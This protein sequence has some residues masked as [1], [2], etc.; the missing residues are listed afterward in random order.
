MK[1]N[2]VIKE[3]KKVKNNK[4]RNIIVLIS[5]L[6]T[7]FIS[8][9]L[10]RGTYLETLEIGEKYINAFW[11]NTKYVFVT[12]IVNAVFLYLSIYF[13]NIK[14][15]NNLAVFF[16]E[17]KKEMIK[18][19]NK[20][21]AFVLSIIVSTITTK[22]LANKAILFFN[23]TLFG[24]F[25]PVTGH[26]IGYFMFQKPLIEFIIMYLLI[27]VVSLVI[28][29]VFYYIITINICFDGINMK[30][31]K[32][33]KIINVLTHY[34]KIFAI[35]ISCLVF[36]NTQSISTNNY[37]D[38]KE[39]QGKFFLIGAGAS[40]IAIKIWG[41]R[42]LCVLIILSVFIAVNQFKKRK[43]KN[44]LVS[45]LIVPTYLILFMISIFGYNTI[46][47]NSNELD[48][49][50]SYIQNNINY[51][52]KAYGISIDEVLIQNGNTITED[53][54][55]KNQTV[56]NNISI[57]NKDMLLKDLQASQ[58][59]KGYYSYTNTQMAKYNIN[60]IDKTIYISPRE[61]SNN[62]VT[63]N[64]KTYEFTHGYGAIIT[65]ASEVDSNGNLVHLQ[66]GFSDSEKLLNIKEPRLYF[67]LETTDTIVTNCNKQNEFDYPI[68]D[69][70][71][72][73]TKENTYN[74]KAGLKLSFIDRFILALKEG[75]IKLA[76]SENVGKNSKILTN[77]NIIDRAKKIMPYLIYDE[78]PYVVINSEGRI[79]WVLDAYTISNQ[80]PYS[81]KTTI[82]SN[83]I[84]KKEFNY[85]RNSVKVLIDS[86]DG[87]ID[88]YITDKTD[89]I[90]MAYKK[91]YK[92]L[93][94][95]EEIP[96]DIKEHLIYPEFLYNIQAKILT[97]YHNVTPDVL[98]RSYDTWD[99]CSHNTG[100]VLT[101]AGTTFNPY[102]TMCKLQ[103]KTESTFGLC[104]PF[105]QYGKQ[106]I[107][108]YLIG[109]YDRS[110]KPNLTLYK[111]PSD[112]NVLGPMQLDTQIEQ[113]EK[114]TK[115]L[116]SL[117]VNG[118]KITKN[119]IVVPVNNTLLYVETI[120]QQYLNE[121]ESALPTLKKVI[122]AS[123]NKL[124]IG[125]NFKESL[126]NLVSQYAVNIEPGVTDNIDDLIDFLI[127]AN[128]NLEQSTNS[129]DWEMM[130]KDVKKLQEIINKLEEVRD[131]EKKK[132]EETL[133]SV[134]TEDE[135][136]E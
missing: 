79:I 24:D 13:T 28:Y 57:T 5:Y 106:N 135:V 131:E 25:D 105:T 99:I 129:K 63:Y 114:I 115:Q 17:E 117:N 98:Y 11:T 62:N 80:Y 107:I 1:N 39:N 37:I 20:S 127:R 66:K 128:K 110:G 2:N 53:D 45:I 48:K 59:S 50:K 47:I 26:D 10:Y 35:L 103:D 34:I 76:F 90:V 44:V 121:G 94:T 92:N 119:M 130:G 14:L 54:V 96:Q 84:D 36:L 83:Y 74:G 120:Y 82:S 9:I 46:F 40:D 8:Y 122:V 31:L 104:I 41:Y 21:I 78:N 118:T 29:G 111:Y 70:S 126:N 75:D 100:L 113:D 102:Y 86:Y 136:Q 61:I 38:L 22:I 55:Q 51:T 15:K 4:K 65:S 87:T 7:I 123:G 19:P 6:V 32:S 64:N 43:T 18:L 124:A 112:S 27:I 77:R 89:P 56:I 73:E 85:I 42:I 125:N 133:K 58:T 3:E 93:F 97:R 134:K 69:S 16:R 71:I 30:T 12:F 52:R 88:F 72:I 91:C 95:E 109:S 49:Q 23:S 108:S 67:G 116:E 81:Q 101:K 60:G 33:S 132:K 68:L